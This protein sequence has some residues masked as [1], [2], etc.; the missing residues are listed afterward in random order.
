MFDMMRLFLYKV[1]DLYSLLLLV[2]ALLSWFPDAYDSKLG[3]LVRQMVSPV[4]KPFRRLQLHFAGMDFT[5]W[6]VM[7][8]LNSLKRL[9]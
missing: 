8:I 6:L 2:Y 7:I 9:L 4:L 3:Q 1:I 5:V